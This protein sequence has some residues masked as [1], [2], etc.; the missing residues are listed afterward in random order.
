M[1]SIG[2]LKNRL[3]CSCQIA[4][5]HV[6]GTAYPIEHSLEFLLVDAMVE[7]VDESRLSEGVYNRLSDVLFI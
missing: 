6:M 3:D 4:V 1:T 2:R 5:Y 7:K